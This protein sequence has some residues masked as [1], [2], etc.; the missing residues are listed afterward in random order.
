LPIEFM[1]CEMGEFNFLRDQERKSRSLKVLNVVAIVL[2][3]AI[4]CVI[5]IAILI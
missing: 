4:L 5:F 3:I 1:I 2:L